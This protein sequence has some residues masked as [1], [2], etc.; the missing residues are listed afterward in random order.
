MTVFTIFGCRC[1]GM[2]S[3]GRREMYI[4]RLNRCRPR[5]RNLRLRETKLATWRNLERS[6][7]ILI[8]TQTPRT[9]LPTPI[10]C[11]KFAG[12]IIYRSHV[13]PNTIASMR[14]AIY[15]N[16]DRQQ[17]LACARSQQAYCNQYGARDATETFVF[18]SLSLP[19]LSSEG[20]MLLVQQAEFRDDRWS[21][22]ETSF[23]ET[24][25]EAE[26]YC[27]CYLEH[28]TL[29]TLLKADSSPFRRIEF[30]GVV[31]REDQSTSCT[32]FRSSE[33]LQP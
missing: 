33:V 27:H 32:V 31:A 8:Y 7:S 3:F 5:E 1:L 16:Q 2:R 10:G 23:V 28:S 6:R 20:G 24:V 25:A 4:S 19:R 9:Q 22:G 29:S 11:F 17:L 21:H 14:L 30:V 15:R 12:E 18:T 13:P 26:A